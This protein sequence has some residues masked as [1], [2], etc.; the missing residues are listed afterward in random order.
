[1]RQAMSGGNAPARSFGERLSHASPARLAVGAFALVILVVATLLSLPIARAGPYSPQ[2]V[3]AIFTATSAVCV[4]GLTT[5]PT[6]EYWSAFGQGVIVA[7]MQVGGLGVMTLGSLLSL[8]A[9]R[10]LGLRSKLL[11]ASETGTSRLGDVGVL[12]RAVAVISIV[13]ELLLTAILT[14]R[15][16]IAG[17]SAGTALWHGFFYGVSA[18]NNAGFVPTR[19]GLEAFASDWWVLAPIMI[20][21]F[22]GSLG[23]PVILDLR[24]HWRHP[25]ALGLHSKLTIS[26]CLAL[27]GIAWVA[28][29]ATEWNN[30]GTLAAESTSTTLLNTLFAGVMTRSGGF[31]TFA[32]TDQHPST[33][34]LQDALMFVGGG[35]ASTAGGIKVTTLAVMLL[36]IRAEARGDRDM[37]AF[38]RRIEPSILRVAVTVAVASVM[39]VFTGALILSFLSQAPLTRILFECI[40]AFA[41]CGLSTGLSAS[42]PPLGKLT[43]AALMLTGRLGTM[44]IATSVAMT[45]RRRVIRLAEERPIVG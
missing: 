37:E 7:G 30:P 18:F 38:G 22:V 15:F 2:L 9:S 36:A 16:I 13:V 14:P 1:M 5:V 44:T 12:V 41:T 40:S 25:S 29:S 32:V 6:A 39:F 27:L 8:A 34:L 11:T 10:R 23:F 45:N 17:E 33:T 19:S 20:A 43:L 21:V 4:T 24:R 28:F 26:F 42:L 31:S 3:D 35:S